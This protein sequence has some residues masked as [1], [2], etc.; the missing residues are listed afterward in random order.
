MK[1]GTGVMAVVGKPFGGLTMVV[2]GLA[3]GIDDEERRLFV[4]CRL[5][6]IVG[7]KW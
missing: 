1:P 3:F 7:V 2:T 5:A 6:L 4:R